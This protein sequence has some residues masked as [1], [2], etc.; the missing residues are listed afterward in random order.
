MSAA[1][2]KLWVEVLGGDDLRPWIRREFPELA[3]AIPTGNPTAGEIADRLVEAIEARGNAPEVLRALARKFP[4]RRAQIDEAARSLRVTLDLPPAPS[5]PTRSTP[6]MHARWPWFVAAAI[7]VV[8][9]SVIAILQP[10]VHDRPRLTSPEETGGKA[11]SSPTDLRGVLAGMLRIDP[12]LLHLNIPPLPARELGTILARDPEGRQVLALRL[13]L[14]EAETVESTGSVAAVSPIPA[15]RQLMNSLG[16]AATESELGA[17]EVEIRLKGWTVREAT[18]AALRRHLETSDD[19]REER[20]KGARL[21]VINRTFEA[22]PELVFRPRSGAEDAWAALRRRLRAS[23]ASDA[24][25]EGTAVVL[26]GDVSAVVAYEVASVDFVADTLGSEAK[27]RLSPVDGGQADESPATAVHGLGR[28]EFAVLAG[29]RYRLNGSLPGQHDAAFVS[30]TL[31]SAGGEPIL[32]L[33]PEELTAA[34]FRDALELIAG[35]AREARPPLL[36]VYYF[37]HAMPLGSGQQVLVMSDYAGDLK[38]DAPSIGRVMHDAE[39]ATHPMQGSNL[40]DL[41]RVAQAV[42][43]EVAPEIPGLVTVAESHR[44]LSAAGV[45]FVLLID[46][47]Y[48]DKDFDEIRELLRLTEIGDYYGDGDG[49]MAEREFHAKILRYGELPL[50]RGADPVVL[51]VR[52]G[53]AAQ[54]VPDPRYGWSLPPRVGPLAR[55]LYLGVERA[56]SWPGLLRGMIDIRPT[57]EVRIDGTI[58]WS[59]IAR[60]EERLQPDPP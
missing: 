15:S 54:L 26:K 20:R 42:E 7:V 55:R 24:P 32:E 12:T 22:V 35:K 13:R 21:Q 57:G 28:F 50:L 17:A 36:V 60:F 48:E 41:L 33:A 49:A 30:E 16:I 53:V 40:E 37:G 14:D 45:P 43:G 56:T 9:A 5:Q 44:I 8:A 47:C 25:G 1:F 11:D 19:V 4:G 18:G 52:P 46:G 10:W 3:E 59:D 58:S 34:A 6:P 38:R 27:V 23:Y 2:H 51:A 29:S 31:R 39:S